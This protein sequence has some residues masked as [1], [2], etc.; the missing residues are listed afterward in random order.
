MF[1][2]FK[3]IGVDFDAPEQ[4]QTYESR[5]KTNLVDDR[6]LIERL[7]IS[8]GHSVIEFGCGTGSFVL[9]AAEVGAAVIAVDISQ[10]ML[11]FAQT[12]ANELGISGIEFVQS[13]FLSYSHSEAPVDF[14]VTK[15]A[16]HHLPDFWKTVALQRL[17]AML[18]SNGKF[19]LEDV[20]FSF[21]PQDYEAALENWIERVSSDS[22]DGFSRADFEIHIREEYSTFGWMLAGML[23]QVGFQVEEANYYAL[24]YADYL[25]AKV[26]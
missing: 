18:K 22:G 24:T 1:N 9:A 2:E 19:Y 10:S 5:Q 16:F 25:C 23:K 17:H 26:G 20:V 8:A 14:I 3:H 21:N 12:K 11:K 15:F 13:G 7:G 4:V 6:E